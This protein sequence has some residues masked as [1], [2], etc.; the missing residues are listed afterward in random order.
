[1]AP[2]GSPSQLSCRQARLPTGS[3]WRGRGP[4][5]R[6]WTWEAA[7]LLP[8]RSPS[9][10]SRGWCGYLSMGEMSSQPCP[11]KRAEKLKSLGTAVLTAPSLQG[12]GRAAGDQGE[13]AGVEPGLPVGMPA[14][15]AG[16]RTLSCLRAPAAGAAAQGTHLWKNN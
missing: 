3:R 12:T 10:F 4:V 11:D 5:T 8:P 9:G 1:M 16:V 14:S 2:S 15:V 13:K 6:G 7:P